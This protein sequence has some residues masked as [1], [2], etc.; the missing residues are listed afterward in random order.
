MTI[1]EATAQ[2]CAAGAPFEMEVV[3]IGG[4]A[5]RSWKHQPPTLAA[6]AEQARAAHGEQTFLVHED[7]RVTYDGWFRATAALAGELSRLG[8]G[9]GDR[10]ALAM[11]NL[12]EWP[13]ALF[14]ITAIGAI[15]VPL[16]GW[17]TGTELSYGLSHSGSAG[18]I[19]DAERWDRVAPRLP[20]LPELRHI[21]VSRAE[22][23]M[24]A[25]ARA[26]EAAIGHPAG[27]A[28]L[29]DRPL[30]ACP[31]AP[32]DEATI[33]YTSGTSGSPKGAL[34]THRNMLHATLTGP[35]AAQRAMLRRGDAPRRNARTVL[36]VVPLFHVTGCHAAMMPTIMTGG[37]LVFMRKWDTAKA[38]EL[39]ARE[40]VNTTG[41]VPTIAWQLLEHPDR[42]AYDLSSLETL[43]YG[44]APSPPE[45]VRRIAGDLA[46]AASNGWGMTETSATVTVH[47]A[48]DYLQRPDSCGPAVPVSDIRIM[49]A[50]GSREL[51]AGEVG[52]LWAFGPQVV[53][54]Y[55]NDPEATQASFRDGWIR[56][57]D[58][59]RLDEEGFCYIVDRAKD[60]VIR[61]G[62]NIYSCEVEHLLYEHPAVIDAAVIG[63]PH[64][65]LGE[66]PAAIV[67][68]AEGLHASEAELQ[69]WVAQRLAAF[70]VPVKVRFLDALLPRNANGKIVKSALRAL[71]ANSD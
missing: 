39:I 18:L 17:W 37:T 60:I 53:K 21:M 31:L 38:L 34:G 6:L 48:E 27:Y 25:P 13:V 54:G 55:W 26:L 59:A 56:S 2:L 3:E 5:T 47:A 40:R 10:V 46:I 41:G 66:E 24:P 36:L 15:A 8:I 33:F 4:I 30:P 64:P 7:E 35:F 70:K 9:K 58:L 45:L 68:L 32:D 62:E 16:N 22:G 28:A 63:L 50:D 69:R 65:T 1:A 61:G 14:A 19:C 67:H 44:G 71:F 23:T 51:P 20:E 11:R 42:G 49:S 12:P 43:A 52:E 29:P 57:G